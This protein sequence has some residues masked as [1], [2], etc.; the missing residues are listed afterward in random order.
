M[1]NCGG[2]KNKKTYTVQFPD[3]TTKTYASATEANAAAA[4]R[5][6]TVKG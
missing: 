1:C 6:G 2:K 3:G 5:G 4:R